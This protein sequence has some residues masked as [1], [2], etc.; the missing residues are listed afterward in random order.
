MSDA[1]EKEPYELELISYPES[2][3]DRQILIRNCQ[4]LQQDLLKRVAHLL[5]N[6]FVVGELKTVLTSY[7][8]N[9]YIQE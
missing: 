2:L 8:N 3:E 9:E 4:I 5:D 6:Q 1:P 7:I